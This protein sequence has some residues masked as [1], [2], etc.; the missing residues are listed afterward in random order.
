MSRVAF[1]ARQNREA[2]CKRHYLREVRKSWMEDFWKLRPKL[3]IQKSDG[4]LTEQKRYNGPLNVHKS[5]IMCG[6]GDQT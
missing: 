5:L 3:N 4:E 1:H 6:A 2:I